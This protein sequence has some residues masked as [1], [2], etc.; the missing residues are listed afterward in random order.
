MRENT[1]GKYRDTSMLMIYLL[2]KLAWIYEVLSMEI[3]IK[4]WKDIEISSMEESCWRQKEKEVPLTN[5]QVQLTRSFHWNCTRPC[6][7]NSRAEI[8]YQ[9]RLFIEPSYI[10]SV[11]YNSQG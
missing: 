10:L 7:V 6:A 3:A 4:S 9:G 2:C 5:I 11:F 8:A 1:G